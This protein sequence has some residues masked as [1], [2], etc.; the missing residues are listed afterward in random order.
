MFSLNVSFE[1]RHVGDSWAPWRPVDTPPYIVVTVLRSVVTV[2][3]CF[4]LQIN[5]TEWHLQDNAAKGHVHEIARARA[6]ITN[7]SRRII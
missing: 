2:N 4:F 3:W 1:W 6:R 7:V 5:E